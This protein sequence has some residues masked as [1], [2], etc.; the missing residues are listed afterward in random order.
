MNA[1]VI[2][3]VLSKTKPPLNLYTF[4]GN[5]VYVDHPEAVLISEAVIAIDPGANGTGAVARELIFLSPDH[6]VRIQHTP[7]KPLRKLRRR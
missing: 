4:D 1:A 2:R 5:V 3:R 6:V 7:R